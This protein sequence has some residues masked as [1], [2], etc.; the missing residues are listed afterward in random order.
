MSR[1]KTRNV[2]LSLSDS[3]RDRLGL[4]TE[5]LIQNEMSF[6]V[7]KYIY[8]YKH[9][10]AT[11]LGWDSD[12]L[13]QYIRL[14]LYRGVVTYSA[15]K[16]VKMTSYLSAILYY[17][18]GNLSIKIQNKKNS[19]SKLYCPEVLYEVDEMIDYTSAEDWMNYAYKFKDAIDILTNIEKKLLVYHLIYGYS[20]K[21]LEDKIKEPRIEIIKALKN[22]KY[23]IEDWK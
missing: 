4:E 14:V 8:D 23:K 13:L 3:E 6:I 15:E 12:D 16:N 9:A 17:Q 5:R 11:T 22:L 10:A 1:N 19:N 7:N 2:L 21:E 18:M 20:L